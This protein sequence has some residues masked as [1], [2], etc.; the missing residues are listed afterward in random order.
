MRARLSRTALVAASCACLSAVGAESGGVVEVTPRRAYLDSGRAE[1]L[2]PGAEL[3][4]LRKGR[5][6]ASCRV[7]IVSEHRAACEG[8]AVRAGDRFPLPT[9]PR[10]AGPQ[11]AVL[12]ELPD[13]AEL[14]RWAK[15][16]EGAPLKRVEFAGGSPRA[17]ALTLRRGVASV[18]LAHATWAAPQ[19]AAGSFHQERLML[20]LYGASLFGLRASGDATLVAWTRPLNTRQPTSRYQ[21]L[22]HRL[23][24]STPDDG[25]FRVSA[26]RLWPAHAASMGMIDGLQAGWRTA[27]KAAEIGVVAGVLPEAY[28]LLPSVSAPLVGAYAAYTT[29][30]AGGPVRWSRHEARISAGFGRAGARLDVAALSRANVLHAVQVLA[31]ARFA[32]GAGAAPGAVEGGSLLVDYRAAESL[33]LFAGGRYTSGGYG[34]APGPGSPT[35]AP[36]VHAEAGGSWSFG[37]VE[38]AA[39]SDFARDVATGS[40]RIEAGPDLSAPRLFGAAGG[41]QAGYRYG[42]GYLGGHLGHLQWV[43]ALGPVRTFVRA[44]YFGVVDGPTGAFRPEYGAYAGVD[45]S[46]SR[47]LSLRASGF[48]WLPARRDLSATASL[49]ASGSVSAQF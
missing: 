35:G 36:S 33:R 46:L 22:V 14:S 43:G 45:L 29:R 49:G 26:G 41:L 32:V 11:P 1:G 13:A 44:H 40:W 30:D 31:D 28:E 16:A 48:A 15:A 37:P 20:R 21:L 19:S 23:E 47:W 2:E 39:S 27:D 3:R 4:L 24:V 12:P 25:A 17:I 6:V 38:V 34:V 42:A 5:P 10:A 18:D 8:S 9:R 7:S